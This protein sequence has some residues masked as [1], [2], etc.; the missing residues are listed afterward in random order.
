MRS[1]NNKSLNAKKST[2][3]AK[4]LN[5]GFNYQMAKQA[6]ATLDFSNSVLQEKELI[7]KEANKALKRYEK[8]YKDTEL[9]NKV[10]LALASRGFESDDIYALINEMEL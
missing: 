6:L 2:I 8:K 10:Y 5:D 7:R 4:L 3:L 9:R 1:V